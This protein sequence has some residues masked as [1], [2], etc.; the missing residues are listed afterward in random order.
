MVG[1]LGLGDVRYIEG[2]VF[3]RDEDEVHA[4]NTMVRF[5][6]CCAIAKVFVLLS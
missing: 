5:T 3:D 2:M 1:M 6:C 4:P